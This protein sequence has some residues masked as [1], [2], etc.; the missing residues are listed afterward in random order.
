MMYEN[1]YR[2]LEVLLVY[3]LYFSA[4]QVINFLNIKFITQLILIFNLL[5]Q[6]LFVHRLKNF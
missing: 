2:T 3:Q 1:I 6:I 4:E 5:T